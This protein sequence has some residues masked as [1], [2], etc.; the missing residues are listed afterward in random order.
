MEEILSKL[1][2]ENQ[3]LRQYADREHLI[4]LIKYEELRKM[5]QQIVGNTKEKHIQ[6]SKELDKN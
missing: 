4:G 2:V 3:L 1:E 5:F 6:L